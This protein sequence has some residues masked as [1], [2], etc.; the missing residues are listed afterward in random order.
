MKK[1][2]Y[3][4]IIPADVYDTAEDGFNMA[5]LDIKERMRMYYMICNWYLVWIKGDKIRVC[6]ETID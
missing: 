2:Y 1:R 4:A 6:R 3:T 5:V